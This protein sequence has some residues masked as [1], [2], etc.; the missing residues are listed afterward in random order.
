MHHLILLRE[1]DQQMSGSGCCGRV[2]GDAAWWGGDGCAFPERRA[3]MD[4]M[5]EIYRAVRRAFPKE[6]E[7]TIVD[8][9]NL[10]SFIPLVVRDAVRN[11]V[12]VLTALQAV[13]S[14]SVATGVLDGQV[15]FSRTIPSPEEVVDTIAGRLSVERVGR[16]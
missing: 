2:E 12:P 6:V 9:R 7:I 4:R 1:I 16:G 15:L 5:G 10:V 13:T 14:T 8:P 11:R 3:T